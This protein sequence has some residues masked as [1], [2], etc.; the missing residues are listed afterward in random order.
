[1]S[2]DPI[3]LGLMAVSIGAGM[4]QRSMQ[5]SARKKQQGNSRQ[6]PED[7]NVSAST[8]GMGIPEI[9]G[10]YRIKGEIIWSE[11]RKKVKPPRNGGKKSGR[12]KSKKGKG[13]AAAESEQEVYLGTFATSFCRG[14]AKII[15]IWAGQKL[16]YDISNP[17]TVE[18]SVRIP[19]KAFKHHSGSYRI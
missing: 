1:M 4:I 19:G 10:T 7:L 11:P 15:K 3:S 18:G 16:I 12:K 6:A 9:F 13:G 8:Y 5:A 17:A 14:P 2:V